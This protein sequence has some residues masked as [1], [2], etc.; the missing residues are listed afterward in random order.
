MIPLFTTEFAR[1]IN[2]ATLAYKKKAISLNKVNVV[3]DNGER[4]HYAGR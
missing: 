1:D 2:L 4:Q 3:H